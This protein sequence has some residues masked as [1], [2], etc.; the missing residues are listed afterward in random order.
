[1]SAVD[2]GYRS[3]DAAYS[4]DYLL[5]AVVPACR[6]RRVGD[7]LDLGCG[8]GFLTR[9]MAQAGFRM[10]GCDPSTSGIAAARAAAGDIRF[11]VAGVDD[12]P[13]IFGADAFDAVVSLEVVEHLPLP[14]NLPRFARAV[15]RPGGY[16]IVSTPYHGYLKNLAIAV[17]G[18]WDA[19][20]DPLWDGGH[21]KFWSEATLRRM[22][23]HEGFVFEQ[24][25]GAG[26]L[27]WL[28]KSMVLVFRKA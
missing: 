11:D 17:L 2:Y 1:M 22:I 25:I 4:G 27:P 5:N 10:T 20:H 21:I 16:L 15:L 24:F 28:W 14:R 8:N 18:H 23:E 7:I 9:Q 13:T 26:R 19:H 12:P 3:A 6:T